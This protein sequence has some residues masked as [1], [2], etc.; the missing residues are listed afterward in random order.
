[1]HIARFVLFHAITSGN[2]ILSINHFYESVSLI[3]IDNARL[4]DSEVREE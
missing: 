4:Y 2:R 1:L 3:D